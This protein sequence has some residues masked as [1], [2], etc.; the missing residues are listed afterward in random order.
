MGTPG[1][2]VGVLSLVAAESRRR[3]TDADIE[4]AREL[5]R[6]A[7]TAIENA[8]LYTQLE[9]VATTSA[10][11]A[12]TGP[13]RSPRLAPRQPLPAGW[14][15]ER[16]RRRLLRRVPDGGGL[17]GRHGRRRGPRPG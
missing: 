15:R 1:R 9:R 16:G 5:G 2:V 8:R 14:R 3:S 12:S 10:R 7:A 4:L 11:P 6:R 13:A 17:D